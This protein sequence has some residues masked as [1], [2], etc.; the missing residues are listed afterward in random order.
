MLFVTTD[1]RR[2]N[3][4]FYQNTLHVVVYVCSLATFQQVSDPPE[5]VLS[6]DGHCPRVRIAEFYRVFVRLCIGLLSSCKLAYD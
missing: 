1:M 4:S 6:F 3:V 5:W 2:L